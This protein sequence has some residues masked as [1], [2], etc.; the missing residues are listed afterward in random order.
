MTSLVIRVKGDKELVAYLGG[1]RGRLPKVM[2]GLSR[3]TA[4]D[5]RDAAKKFMPERGVEGTG[6][7]ATHRSI[8]V[9][10]GADSMYIV[11]ADSRG[12]KY[13]EK[14]FTPHFVSFKRLRQTSR[15]SLLA[16]EGIKGGVFVSR[17]TSFMSPAVDLVMTSKFNSNA[18]KALDNLLRG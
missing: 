4:Y 1:V 13:Q 16:R 15:G 3:D 12:A 6:S 11:S 10:R 8:R 2:K 5:I 17:H 18:K 14:G 7:G 9:K